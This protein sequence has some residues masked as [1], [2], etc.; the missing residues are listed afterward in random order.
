MRAAMSAMR[1]S[2]ESK[3]ADLGYAL[4][5]A[6]RQIIDQ[7]AQLAVEL[8]F[9]HN[10][11]GILKRILFKVGAPKG[12]YL[13]GGVGRGK[14]FLMDLFYEHIKLKQKKRIHFHRFMQE[15]HHRLKALQGRQNPLQKIGK[16]IAS[17]TKLLCLDEFHISDIGDAMIMRNLLAAL[18]DQEVVIV[19]TANW[20]PDKL[21]EH[22]LQ[23]TQFLPTID[24]IKTRMNVV[25]LDAGEDYRLSS[26]EKAG[27]YFCGTG[28]EVESAVMRLF[29][30]LVADHEFTNSIELN[31]RVVPTKR[32]A[33]EAIWFDFDA[34]CDGPRGKDDYIELAKRF[35]TVFISSVP[36]FDKSND[37]AR[38]RFTWLIDEFYDRRVN[39]VIG[40]EERFTD[41]LSDSLGST[42]KDRTESRLIEMQTSRYLGEAHLA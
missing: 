4:D 15:V 32:I 37:N 8:E 5:S 30:S 24:L 26:L 13:W 6:Q 11:Q 31:N 18:F 2:I 21:Y 19:T 35:H 16:D 25:N 28:M 14:T 38:R 9:T 33:K 20:R 23:R 39:I 3:A 27:V 40:S 36:K 7:L 22:G 12:M 42:E 10:Q 34:I 17:Q 41:L 29:D 1:Q